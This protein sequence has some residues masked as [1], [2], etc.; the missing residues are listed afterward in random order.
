VERRA[1]APAAAR[2]SQPGVGPGWAW[3]VARGP[4]ARPMPHA[5]RVR[6]AQRGTWRG[7]GRGPWG[8]EARA[9]HQAPHVGEPAVVTEPGEHLR[10]TVALAATDLLERH[11]HHRA[12]R[13]EI[14]RMR[15]P[16]VAQLAPKQAAGR[17]SARVGSHPQDASALPCQGGARAARARRREGGACARVAV[18]EQHVLE[19]EVAMH[20]PL[21]VEVAH[22]AHHLG[23]V[24]H[25]SVLL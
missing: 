3:G 15:Q 23:E 9:A 17:A 11:T 5:R 25:R 8:G 2:G 21:L 18:A 6:G 19:L 22:C 4:R 7:V 10:R 12:A 13:V 24:A 20:D 14:V 1:R 16:K